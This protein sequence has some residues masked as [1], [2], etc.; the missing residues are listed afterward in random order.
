MEKIMVVIS[1][2]M[3]TSCAP[4]PSSHERH[5]QKPASGTASEQIEYEQ[6][7]QKLAFGTPTEQIEI[8]ISALESA[9]PAA[10][11]ALVGHLKD[12]TRAADDFQ[13]QDVLWDLGHPSIGDVCFDIIQGQVEGRWP[14]GYRQYYVLTPQN[15]KR[16][17]DAHKGLS[18]RELRIAAAQ[19]SLR[20]AE[21]EI[22]HNT[23]NDFQKGMIKFLRD[24]LQEARE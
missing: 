7:I 21:S 16:W 18:L 8:A 1:V 20:R 14:K 19:E 24:N 5:I 9:G 6:H 12:S 17:L 2:L 10:Y 15:T 4:T 23:A 3:I 11:P 22:R 13:T